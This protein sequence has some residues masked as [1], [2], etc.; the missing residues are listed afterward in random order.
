MSILETQ[1]MNPSI[2]HIV[3][4][5]NYQ[6]TWSQP[7]TTIV[8]GKTNMLPTSTNPMWY[9]VIPPFVPL[10]CNLY[11]TYP[12][13]TKGFDSSIFMNYTSYV[14]RLCIGYIF[15]Q[16]IG[17]LIYTPYFVGISFL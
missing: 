13:G 7:I 14:P 6:T 9:N 8:Q 2:G 5:I 11:P 4:P 3:V 16:P 1:A 12:I 15:E 10:N 17:P